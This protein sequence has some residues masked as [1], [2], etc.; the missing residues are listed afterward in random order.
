VVAAQV[1]AAARVYRLDFGKA[2]PFPAKS[3]GELG[4][5]T[6]PAHDGEADKQR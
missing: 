2:R 4:N 6:G 1:L 5:G 3:L